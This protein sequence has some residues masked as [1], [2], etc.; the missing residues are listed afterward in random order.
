MP[1]QH[2]VGC[3]DLYELDL[4]GPAPCTSYPEALRRL[5]ARITEEDKNFLHD[6]KIKVD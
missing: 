4:E 3:A 2:C 5:D 6:M 1:G